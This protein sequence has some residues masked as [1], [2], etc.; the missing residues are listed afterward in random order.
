MISGKFK[1]P[2]IQM[3]D[4]VFLWQMSEMMFDRSLEYSMLLLGGLYADITMSDLLESCSIFLAIISQSQSV[5]VVMSMGLLL[6][7]DL[8]ASM[9]PP[10]PSL[11]CFY[12][13]FRNR[14]R[15][16]RFRCCI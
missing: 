3:V 16:V 6:V 12:G 1:S 4:F 9:T 2:P 11:F 13:I 10:N 8:I 15:L 5:T 7:F 14:I